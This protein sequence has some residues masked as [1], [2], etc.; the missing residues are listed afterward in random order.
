MDIITK[1]GQLILL[2]FI[3]FVFTG[4]LLT[5]AVSIL[6]LPGEQQSTS[7]KATVLIQPDI[8]TTF[9][10]HADIEVT[11]WESADPVLAGSGTG[12]LTYVVTAT[13]NGPDDASGLELSVVLS[14]P[15][16]VIEDSVTPSGATTWFSPTWTIGNLANAASETLTITLT[17]S[18]TT[19]PGSDVISVN[20]DVTAVN[21]ADNDLTNN[22]ASEAT[23]VVDTLAVPVLSPLSLLVLILILLALGCFRVLIRIKSS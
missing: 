21:E 23:T 19:A 2:G 18:G 16:G 7:A 17:V 5:E 15:T 9:I 11:I 4:P 6:D 13:N 10:I 20:S 3:I 12:N 8:E 1:T 22:S 14:L